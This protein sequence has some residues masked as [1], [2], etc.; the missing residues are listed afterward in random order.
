LNAVEIEA[1]EKRF[2]RVLALRGL[3]TAVPAGE[4]ILVSGPNGAG[5]ST[6]LRILAGL[7]RPTRGRVRVLGCDPFH[8]ASAESRG[9]IDYLGP[10]PALYGELSIEENL[11]FCA[12]MHGIDPGRIGPAL[13]ELGLEEVRDQQVR[14][15]SQGFRRRAGLARANLREPELL[16]LDE[17]WNGLDS[18]ASARLYA[19]LD[20][21]RER[22]AT[23]LI[24]AHGIDGEAP[25]FDRVLRLERGAL[26]RSLA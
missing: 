8:S 13:A 1:L 10:E 25:G 15:L 5:K 11:L 21:A 26:Y 9:R 4:R 7:T 3:S 22:G 12:R 17:P 24:A 23:V 2:G 20:R 19:V 6:L 14:T 18:E 16:L